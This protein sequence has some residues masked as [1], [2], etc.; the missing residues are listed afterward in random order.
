MWEIEYSDEVA[1][2]F[3]GDRSLAFRLLKILAELMVG[4]DG[5]PPSDYKDV[6]GVIC[7]NVLEHEIY[8]TRDVAKHKIFVGVIKPL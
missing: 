8:Y 4:A 1:N 3:R 7:W 6:D 2:Y 5:L